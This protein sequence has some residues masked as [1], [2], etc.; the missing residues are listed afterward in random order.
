MRAKTLHGAVG[1]LCN[2]LAFFVISWLDGDRKHQVNDLCTHLLTCLLTFIEGVRQQSGMAANMPNNLDFSGLLVLINI[3][4]I[5]IVHFPQLGLFAGTVHAPEGKLPP[6]A[7]SL[8]CFYYFFSLYT[9]IMIIIIKIID[10][11]SSD[12]AF[13]DLS[14]YFASSAEIEI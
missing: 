9:I 7:T 11:H 3:I 6:V 10:R 1:E 5:I 14:V 4:I 2:R 8:E 12:G 13:S